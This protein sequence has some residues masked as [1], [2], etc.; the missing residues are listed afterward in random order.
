MLKDGSLE[1]PLSVSFPW[2]MVGEEK[3]FDPHRA[4]VAHLDA[5]L[6]VKCDCFKNVMYVGHLRDLILKK[7]CE[8]QAAEASKRPSKPPH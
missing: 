3:K 6:Q 8:D 5:G 4:C 7:G 1:Y 2:V